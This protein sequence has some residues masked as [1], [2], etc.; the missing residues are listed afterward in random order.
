MAGMTGGSHCPACLSPAAQRTVMRRDCLEDHDDRR[1]GLSS[2]WTARAKSVH[3][4][5]S[6]R[7]SHPG[8]GRKDRGRMTERRFNFTWSQT[9]PELEQDYVAAD[10]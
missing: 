5:R 4:L 10:G 3:G 1:S 6:R 8:N 9:W 2:W 7:A